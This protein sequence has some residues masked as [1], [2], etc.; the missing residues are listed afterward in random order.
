MAKRKTYAERVRENAE[1]AAQRRA[2]AT[3]ARGGD[4]FQDFLEQQAKQ[5]ERLAT[6]EQKAPTRVQEAQKRFA[7]VQA[8]GGDAFQDFLN[9]AKQAE[10][11]R[12]RNIPRTA[13]QRMQKRFA[14][15]QAGGGDAFQDFL[16]N[17]EQP[18]RLARPHQHLLR[19]SSAQGQSLQKCGRRWLRMYRSSNSS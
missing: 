11:T 2:K 12:Q 9:Q 18:H 19:C 10:E 6:P 7:D 14:D 13:E 8:G 1:K 5:R 16:T 15:V 3:A 17:Q 4:P